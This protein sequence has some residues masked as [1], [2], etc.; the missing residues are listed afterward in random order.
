MLLEGK[1]LLITGVLTRESIAYAAAKAA[2]EH[3]AEIVLTSFGRAMGLTEKSAKR[4]PQPVDVLEMDATNVEHVRAVA[5][6]L[7]RR[8]GR[9]DGFLH[10]IAFAPQDALGGNFLHTPWESVGTAVQV[11]AFSLK[12]IAEEMLP[13]MR[14]HGGSIVSLDFDARVAWPIYDWMGVAKAA[15]ESVTRYLAR[16][17]GP[18]GVRVNTVSAGPLRTIAGKGIPG[19]QALADGWGDRAPLG[20]DVTDAAPVAD[21]IAFLFSDLARGITGE[22]LHVDGGYHAIGS[23]PVRPDGAPEDPPAG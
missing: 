1:K 15:L 11:S 4:L 7:G 23:A 18:H 2:Q 20:W 3:G 12:T 10:A 19:F 14:E 21:A 17:L 6:E 9:V 5:D 8:W 22:M 16:D 13:H